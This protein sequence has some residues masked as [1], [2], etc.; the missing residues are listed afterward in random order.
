MFL[1]LVDCI[2]LVFLSQLRTEEKIQRLLSDG[3]YEAAI[4]ELLDCQAAST[5]FSRFTCVVALSGKLKD[6]LEV[7]EELLDKALAKV[8]IIKSHLTKEILSQI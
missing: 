5:S 3:C 4:K 1:K 8:S 6:T 2:L 7:T